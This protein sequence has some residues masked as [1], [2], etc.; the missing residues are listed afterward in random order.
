MPVIELD[1][2]VWWRGPDSMGLLDFPGGQRKQC[3]I[4]IA[5]TAMG[6]ADEHIKFVTYPQYVQGIELP[7]PIATL[8]NAYEA[9]KD[10]YQLNDSGADVFDS[11]EV[12]VAAINNELAKHDIDLQFV[13]KRG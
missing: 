7:E 12:R 9:A 4:G 1:P 11:D 2:N 6:V 10:V 8:A 5:C 13:L 3:C